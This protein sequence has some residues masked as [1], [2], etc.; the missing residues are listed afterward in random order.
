M[1]GDHQV[2]RHQSRCALI[3]F[4]GLV[5]VGA[6]AV[7]NIIIVGSWIDVQRRNYPMMKLNCIAAAAVVSWAS[8]QPAGPGALPS[9][10][11]P[12]SYPNRPL[13]LIAPLPPGG[14]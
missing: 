12:P 6:A 14:A 7:R 4:P 10:D 3:A 1:V 13:R 8:G 11:S 5:L 9:M 2:G